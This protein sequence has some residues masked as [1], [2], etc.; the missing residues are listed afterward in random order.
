MFFIHS[1]RMSQSATSTAKVQKDSKKVYDFHKRFN[2]HASTAIR[3]A[4]PEDASAPIVGLTFWMK[5]KVQTKRIW[6]NKSFACITQ[7][8][9]DRIVAILNEGKDPKVEVPFMRPKKETA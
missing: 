6:L 8:Q 5:D 4:K 2:L 9:F 1:E 7:D 3:N